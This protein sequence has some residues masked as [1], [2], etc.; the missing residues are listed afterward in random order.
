MCDEPNVASYATREGLQ[1]DAYPLTM[2][3]QHAF[4]ASPDYQRLV[5]DKLSLGAPMIRDLGNLYTAAMP[6][7][8]AAGLEQALEEDHDLT[9][10]ELLT[11]GYGSGDAAE[12]IPF[13][14]APGW[15]EATRRIRF[16][17]AMEPACDLTQSQYEA[18]HDG[19]RAE[20]LGYEPRREFVIDR[21]GVSEDRHFQDNGIE[22]YRYAS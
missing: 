9:G 10:Q 11:F 2:A 6:A 1:N 5:L 22:Y 8:L 21:V 18:L 4:R 12:V 16:A 7:W 13:Y 19:R 3:V 15:R 20:G 17:A 14:V